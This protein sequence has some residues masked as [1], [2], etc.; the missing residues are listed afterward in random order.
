MN[1]K[2]K[3]NYY[4]GIS[5]EQEGKI[6]TSYVEEYDF[7]SLSETWLDEKGWNAMKDRL[8]KT[9]EWACS[10]ARKEKKRGRAKGGFIIGKRIGWG[11]KEDRSLIRKEW[12]GI[13]ISEITF[14][15][16]RMDIVSIYGDQGGKNLGIKIG[17]IKGE[18]TEGKN[19][20]IGDFNIRIGELGGEDLENGGKDRCSK[21][22]VMDW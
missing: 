3:E 15:G 2:N 12:E 6:R 10:Y 22:K 16:K 17:M 4:Y 11:N 21:D 13:I 5:Q 20:I 14:G 19:I 1:R 18:C 7:V 8:P 9:H